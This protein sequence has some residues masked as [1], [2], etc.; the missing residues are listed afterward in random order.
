M[1]G[2]PTFGARPARGGMR[3]WTGLLFLAGL[4]LFVAI[5]AS[6]DLDAVLDA[7]LGA[8]PGIL[9]IMIAPL[10]YFVL[11]TWG[12]LMLI[13]GQRPRFGQALR[14]YVAAEALDDLWGGVLGEPLKVFVV[15]GKDRTAGIGSVT[16]DNLALF[17]ALVII[18]FLGGGILAWLNV[19]AIFS[20]H[21]GAALLGLLGLGAALGVLLL[22]GPGRVGR[23]LASR[24][25]GG[26]I[27]GFLDRYREVTLH[28]RNF[29]AQHTGRFAASVGLH[30]L[31]KIWLIL[32]VWLT[33]EIMG[34]YEPGRAIWLGLGMQLI[35]LTAT[36]IPA[37]IGVFTGTLAFL[38]E[39]L[40]MVASVA[41]AVAL[42]RRARSLVWIGVGLA[43]I[44]GLGGS[45]ESGSRAN[46]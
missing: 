11:H 26:A 19:E 31:A 36:P 6:S 25:P 32:E 3:W 4:G 45:T 12:W 43:L 20:R 14:A 2:T 38:G 13:N 23:R 29:L 10:G 37:Q 21:L 41:L 15:P 16:L 34:I 22:L 39:T 18:L 44:R 35:H 42:L 27:A 9:L 24:F 17:A 33:L 46:E 8:G 7:C 28:N 1:T 40:G 30:I 5:L